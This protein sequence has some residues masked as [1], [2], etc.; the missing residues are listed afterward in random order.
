M[1]FGVKNAP[2][3][4]ARNT[5]VALQ[6]VQGTVS[7]FDDIHNGGVTWTQMLQNLKTTSEEL[8]RHGFYLSFRKT[9]VGKDVPLLGY[10]RT[11][12]GLTAD[13]VRVSEIRGLPS[14]TTKSELRSQIGMMRWITPVV[15][16]SDAYHG[17][18]EAL[19]WFDG[20]ASKNA[21]FDW[22]SDVETKWRTVLEM[23]ANIV[24]LAK[25]DFSKDFFLDT[26][27]SKIGWGFVLYQLDE[28][29]NRRILRIGS[30]PF[31][32]SMA[33][34]A[35]VHQEAHAVVNAFVS[36]EAWLA[37]GHSR[38]RSDIGRCCGSCATSSPTSRTGASR[39][40][41]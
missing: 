21:T 7:Y 4:F 11:E 32:G 23:L 8:R 39:S 19:G 10:R 18:A 33:D 15:G 12:K 22:T 28:E 26:D 1:P 36:C 34:A 20:L 14:P 17:L 24:A 27:A 35:P 37:Y 30:K 2:P 5:G 40:S 9:H 38:R 41:C 6:P 29:G 13:P 31:K 3:T 25:P 16:G